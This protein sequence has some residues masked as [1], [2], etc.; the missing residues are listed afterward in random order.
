MKKLIYSLCLMIIVN[1]TVIPVHAENTSNAVDIIGASAI[2]IEME[3]GDVLYEKNADTERYPASITKIMTAL[4]V[5]EHRNLDDTITYTQEALSSIESG[6]SAAYIEPGETLTIEQSLY[7]MM[8]HS[9]NDIAHGL[10]YEVGGDLEG[11]ANLMNKKASEL[12]CSKTNFVNASGLNAEDQHTTASDMAKIGKAAYDNK[13][14]RRIMQTVKYELPATNKYSTARVWYNGNR[15]IREGS[16]Y[17]YEPCIGGKTGYTVAAGGTLVTFAKIDDTVL[18]CVILKSMNSASAYEDSIKL[19]EYAEKNIDFSAYQNRGEET[20]DTDSGE[21]V[22]QDSENIIYDKETTIFQKIIFGIE[23]IGI[24][25][26]AM[27]IG[28]ILRIIYVQHERK[29]RRQRRIMQRRRQRDAERK[30]RS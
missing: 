29:K 19:Y 23:V 24:I 22:D 10:A 30:R 26:I 7:V 13:I 12:G 5:L 11:F 1:L 6:S 16:E 15:M 14:L 9:A 18:E 8:L 20:Q 25:F 21:G 3:S 28:I 4:I 2:V 17:Y 27:F